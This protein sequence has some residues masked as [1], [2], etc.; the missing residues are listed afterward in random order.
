[1]EWA[2]ADLLA[3]LP[4]AVLAA[5]ALVVT[6]QIAVK[7][8]HGVA[9]GLTVGG[10]VL[11]V[12]SLRWA[13]AVAP[14][15]VGP[16]VVLDEF[17]LLIIGV[18]AVTGAAVAL[19]AFGYL[20]DLPEPPDELYVLLLVATLGAG[21]LAAA[22]HVASLFIGLETLSVALYG[23]V[24]Y[25]HSRPRSAEAGIKYL[26]VAAV[27]SAFLLF[28]A[29]LLYA[30]TGTLDL[31][32]MARAVGGVTPWLAAGTVLVLAAVGFKL[33]A[34][35]FHL[36]ALDVY[37]GSPAP[38][39][40]FLATVSKAGVVAVL[41]RF[42]LALDLDG[43]PA[44]WRAVAVLSVASILGGNLLAL[45]QSNVKRL[46]AGSSIA[47]MGYLLVAVLAGGAA[48]AEAATVSLIAYIV[49]TVLAFGV[50]SALSAGAEESEELTD[51]RGLY[52]RRPWPAAGLTVAM[53]SL[54]G[55]PL[56]AGFVG[57]YWLLAAGVGAEAWVPVLVLVAGSVIGLVYYLRVVATMLTPADGEGGARGAVPGPIPASGA[58]VLV[59]A[60][61]LLLWFG[62]LPQLLA[63]AVGAAVGALG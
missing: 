39:T 42:A 48:G 29:A 25:R 16:L 2:R 27:A 54:A 35:P 34:V 50:V 1:M 31:I 47:H 55:I 3:L 18:V 33:A 26:I 59:A 43:V 38:V 11:T 37:E 28:G 10:L 49:T 14:R 58:F 53:L 41:V 46:L 56:T 30:E 8:A 60:A 32:G 51:Y 15:G 40:A 6:V 12:A 4:L 63:G 20:R 52:W 19:L 24:A 9:A 21:V 61:L 23:L 57:K 45:L 7:R 22:R 62:V 17:A 5:T 13:G 36:W 44:L